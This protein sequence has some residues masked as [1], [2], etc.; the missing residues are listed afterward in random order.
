MYRK[1]HEFSFESFFRSNEMLCKK[2]LLKVLNT[3]SIISLSGTL[4]GFPLITDS[5]A[6]M[7]PEEQA[8]KTPLSMPLPQ[9]K[10][11]G[12]VAS[13]HPL[14]T[15][16]G[17]RILENGG[18]AFDAAIAV[19]SAL[20]V[21][22]P[23]M[24]GMG[25]YG[26]LLIYDANT[27]EVRYLNSS[28]RFPIRTNSDLMR[29]PTE[30]YMQ[31]RRGPKSISTPG[32]LN[33][34]ESMH[35]QYGT[36]E[37]KNLFKDAIFYA[38]QG[39]QIPPN[40]AQWL[41]T[42]FDEFP[43]Y[44]KLFYGKEGAHLQERDTLI[45]KDLA[46]TLKLIAEEGAKPFYH[47]QIAQTIDKQMQESGSFLTLEDLEKNE[48]E[49][50]KPI[51]FN[52]KGYDIY[53]AG[54]PANSF[55]AFIMLGLMQQLESEKLGHN[56]SEYLH[57]LAE[58]AKKS[59]EARLTYS[60]DPEINPFPLEN[61]LSDEALQGLAKSINRDKASPYTPPF[62]KE[63]ANTTHFVVVDSQGNIVSATQTLGNMFGSRIMIKGTGI[64]MNSSMLFGTFEPKGNP[65]DVF[66][67]R[68]KLS[69]D[70]PIIIMK[71]E[72]PWAALGT[73]GGHTITQNVPQIISN[74]IDFEMNMQESI[75]S[76][77]LAFIEPN[78]IR[79]EKG[80][81][82]ATINSLK[83]KGHQVEEGTIGNATGIR[84]FH[85]E[86]II[87]TLEGGIDKRRDGHNSIYHSSQ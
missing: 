31:N 22:E 63:S 23:M 80:V 42:T 1:I 65:M 3:A 85:D 11:K 67:G 39:F 35:K 75:D 14:A 60:F 25:G 81:S 37:W 78:I 2:F 53:T 55:S 9:E 56:T 68:H 54:P 86:D 64:W 72:H 8:V 47:G 58:A 45:Q 7:D 77:K 10:I 40:M 27:K 59:D 19:A 46:K 57:L 61:I 34:W 41:A 48:A 5:C 16:A 82:Q 74:L 70:C 30:N 36:K 43:E 20:N 83:E 6:M 38:E 15:Q 18:N 26:T 12:Q 29:E 71:N 13:A 52:Y 32:N 87:S 28:G 4:L 50:G 17:L 76:P 51:K 21:V 66:P 62:G 79:V 24:S 84:I 49:W 73:P 33:A 44:A 69:G